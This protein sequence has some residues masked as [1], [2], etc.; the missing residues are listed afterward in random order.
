MSSRTIARPYERILR[1][2]PT[3]G[4]VES[5]MQSLVDLLWD[6]LSAT[7]VSWIGFYVV[8]EKA[9]EMVLAARR[10]KPACSP[11]GLHGACGQALLARRAL[12]VRDVANLG[13]GYI[14]C[15]P[16][17]RSEVVVPVLRREGGSGE[18]RAWGVL[19]ADSY[20]TDSFGVEDA[21]RF[22]EVLV[23]SGLSEAPGI[24]VDVV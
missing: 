18:L 7:G 14:A 21:R 12:V 3:D 24:E 15:D 23:K 9:G 5:R 8:G 16:R 17:D 4:S 13:A 6:S 22:H 19:D 20:D 1:S 11:I 10:D 2:V